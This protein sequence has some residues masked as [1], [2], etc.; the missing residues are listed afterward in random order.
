MFSSNKT[1]KDPPGFNRKMIKENYK[2][3]DGRPRPSKPNEARQLPV[4]AATLGLLFWVAQRFSA[5]VKH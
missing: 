1:F 3:R 4:V 5:A 2:C